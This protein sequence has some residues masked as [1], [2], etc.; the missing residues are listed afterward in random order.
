MR[1]LF[2]AAAVAASA[3]LM[4]SGCTDLIAGHPVSVFADPFRVA[5]LPAT[6][7]PSGLRPD[8]AA[9]TRDVEDGNGG[10]EDDLAVQSVSDVEEFWDGAYQ[11]P[12][13]GNFQPAT[14]LVSWDSTEY[15]THHFCGNDTYDFVNAV[16]C[17]D[18]N[19]IG[20][21]RGQLLPLLRKTFG[22]ISI[23]LVLGHE[24][25]HA[26][27]RRAHLAGTATP[28]LVAE[29]QADCFAGAYM[30]WVAE[31]QSPRFTMSTGDGL[32]SVLA[33]VIS[34]RDPVQSEGESDGDEHGSAFER[35]SAFQFG[36]TDGAASCIAIDKEEVEKRRGDLP[37]ALTQDTTGE[38]PVSEESVTAIVDAMTQ[39]FS[40]AK[41]PNLSFDTS[42]ADACPD[43][44]PSPPAS[45]CPAT[46]TIAVD[47]DRLEEM[48]APSEQR[49]GFG[50]PLG[51]NTAYSVVVSRYMLAIQEQKQPS[52]VLDNASAALRT[53]CLTGVATTKM[54]EQ[55]NVN[56][57]TVQLAA[58]DLDEAVSGMLTNG[59]AASDVNG[60][61][62]P[63]GFSRIDAFRTGVLG[64]E[65]RCFQRYP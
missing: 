58:G 33:T 14:A 3:A 47:L 57:H 60:E 23:P 56:G 8:A 32:N 62:V 53:A 22:D 49:G 39:A 9:P 35:I 52:V 16:Y 13:E 54:S 30:R 63:S 61:S 50:L 65:N 45:Y 11:P 17:W 36:F 12:L 27:Q 31:G 42:E 21:D 51:D 29:Q 18:D 10:E 34:L 6:D 2:S 64:D 4:V 7:G 38:W 28:S 19:N 44:R 41:P 1:P 40:P 55:I 20:W 37:V 15:S 43:A 5:G 26:V 46:N 24:Y 25:G 48:G 59:L